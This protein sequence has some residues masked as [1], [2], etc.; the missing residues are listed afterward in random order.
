MDKETG[1]A[2]TTP[3]EA[4]ILRPTSWLPENAAISIEVN[5]L[6]NSAIGSDDEPEPVFGAHLQETIA[7]FRRLFVV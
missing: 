1:S 3:E 2:N 6:T 5:T 4:L 7:A